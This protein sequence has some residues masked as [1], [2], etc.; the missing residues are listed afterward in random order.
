MILAM[1]LTRKFLKRRCRCHVVES[2]H[3]YIDNFLIA[4]RLPSQ[5]AP[6]S[7]PLTDLEK[8]GDRKSSSTEEAVYINEEPEAVYINEEPE[9]VYV[10]EEPE[11]VY[12]NE[13][14]EAV[15]I[16]E[17][18]EAVYMNEET[19]AMYVNEEPEPVYINEEE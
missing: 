5:P 10:N 2:E 15:Y 13:E 1:M 8:T 9:A 18:P 14:P 4:P 11:A 12:I 6:S 16:N 7:L 17:E 3:E 19:E